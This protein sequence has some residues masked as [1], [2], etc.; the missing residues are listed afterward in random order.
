M[1]STDAGNPL[2]I[3]FVGRLTGPK[4]QLAR[5]L[6]TKVFGHFAQTRFLVVGG[7]LTDELQQGAPDNV[8]FTGWRTGLQDTFAEADLVIG[9]GRVA[10]E[11][12]KAGVPV[13]AVGE[14]CRAGYVETA[15][16]DIAARSNFG[17]CGP[18]ELIDTSL[19]IRDLTLFHSGYRPATGDIAR[20][21]DDYQGTRVAV[22]I[23]HSYIDALVERRLKGRELPILCYHRVVPEPPA[24]PGPNIHVTTAMMSAHLRQLQQRGMRTITFTDLIGDRPLPRRPVILTFDDG[25]RDNYQYLLPLLERYDA[26]A[27]IFALGERELAANAWDT[28]QGNPEHAL[29]SDA[30]LRACHA[31][32]RVEIGSHGLSHPHLPEVDEQTLAREVRESKARLETLL[33]APV[34]SFAYPYGE[35]GGRERSA[36]EAAGYTFGVATDRGQKIDRD[37]YAIARRIVF[38]NTGGFG[39]FKKSSRWYP[40][41]RRMLGRP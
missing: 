24:E 3:A 36:V 25:Y 29:M 40:A 30:E 21:L 7:P 37:R 28:R 26:R 13:Y 9:S 16:F 41:Y 1:P 11:A 23:E 19:I 10:L 6:A 35:H 34:I 31:S 12:L 2:C 22:A 18:G 27:V 20:L 38:P 15:T 33:G 17:D 14:A 4:G 5:R 8:T 32:G 39:F